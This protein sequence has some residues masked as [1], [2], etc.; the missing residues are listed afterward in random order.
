MTFRD[1]GLIAVLTLLSLAATWRVAPETMDRL[2]EEP[3]TPGDTVLFA[4]GRYE[5]LWLVASPGS[6][7][8]PRG[9]APCSRQAACRQMPA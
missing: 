9:T 7:T 3:P 5:G 6:P 4:D 2:R 1:T 8:G